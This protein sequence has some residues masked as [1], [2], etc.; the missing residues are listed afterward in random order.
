VKVKQKEKLII[1]KWADMKLIFDDTRKAI[2]DICG[3]EPHSIKELSV[4]LDL[5][6]G[7]IHNHIKKLFNAGYLQIAETRLIN[8]I[9]EKKY[10]R[11]AK[12]FSFAELKGEEN[13]TRN[14]YIANEFSKDVFATLEKDRFATARRVNV[15][16]SRE[17]YKIAAEKLK[18][19][20]QFLSHSNG[21]GE[22][23]TNLLL[24]LG[25]EQEN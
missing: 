25:I 17:N 1:K 15:Q 7:C 21:S 24:C 14:K 9:L 22:I 8:G 20:I 11:S 12:F 2:V 16:L 19:L 18:D 4:K 23:N 5:N 6:P 10:L 3:V 13:A